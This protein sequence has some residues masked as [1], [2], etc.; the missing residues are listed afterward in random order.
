LSGGLSSLLNFA[1][2][3]YYFF[4][5]RMDNFV[6]LWEYATTEIYSQI[7]EDLPEEALGVS[8][9][10]NIGTLCLPERHLYRID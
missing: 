1:N 9:Y 5:Q 8:A 3:A 7:K 10:Q 4:L 6:N 2:T